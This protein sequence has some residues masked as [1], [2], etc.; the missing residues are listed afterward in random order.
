MQI[1]WTLARSFHRGQSLIVLD[2]IAQQDM[3]I[4]VGCDVD[5]RTE[6][7]A[8]WGISDLHSRGR[9]AVVAAR[10]D[11]LDSVCICVSAERSHPGHALVQGGSAPTGLPDQGA[12]EPI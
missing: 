7:H 12:C 10:D 1:R 4:S 8:A 11:P 6:Q 9:E 5:G 2:G 3:C